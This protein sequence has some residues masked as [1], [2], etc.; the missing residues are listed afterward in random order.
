MCLSGWVLEYAYL[1]HIFMMVCHYHFCL[2]PS[3]M[4]E[5]A[6]AEELE[7]ILAQKAV[8]DAKIGVVKDKARKECEVAGKKKR[9]QEAAVEKKH[10]KEA[11]VQ[12][13]WDDD[14]TCKKTHDKEAVWRKKY[15]EDE[16]WEHQA[17]KCQ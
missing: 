4:L 7:E 14:A 17:T 8:F 15:N 6:A 9:Q 3:I 1:G 12:K 16:E 2:P 5:K 13:K 11:N 10:E